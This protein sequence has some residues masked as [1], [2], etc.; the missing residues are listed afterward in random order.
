MKLIRMCAALGVMALVGAGCV[1]EPLEGLDDAGGGN[2]SNSMN[3]DAGNNNTMTGDSGGNNGGGFNT[4]F[5]AVSA[6]LTSNCTNAAGCHDAGNSPIGTSSF[7]INGGMNA[8]P[9]DVQAALDGVTAMSSPNM[10]IS[11]SSP[12]MSEIFIRI[13]KDA[14]DPLLMGQGAFGA[15]ATPLDQPDIDAIDAWITAGAPYMQ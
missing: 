10:L 12:A 2:N 15:A 8:G 5:V 4:D 6:I 13:T 11:P 1:P 9:A 14:S 7:T 3:T